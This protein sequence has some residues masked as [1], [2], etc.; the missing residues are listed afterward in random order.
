MA[1]KS[2]ALNGDEIRFLRK[3]LGK[4]AADFA[5]QIGISEEHLSRMEN[6][7][8]AASEGTDK[9][10][11]L[12]YALQSKDRI[13]LEQLT[14]EIHEMFFSWVENKKKPA[15]IVASVEQSEWH[16]RLMAAS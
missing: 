11:R 1:T 12:V 7:R 13:L 3:R 10:I 6:N 9:L 15:R 14:K 4:K 16:T 5:R 2:E 8:L